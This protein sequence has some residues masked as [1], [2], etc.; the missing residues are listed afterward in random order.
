[1][2]IRAAGWATDGSY[3]EKCVQHADSH[4]LYRFDNMTAVP[5]VEEKLRWNSDAADAEA[6]WIMPLIIREFTLVPGY[7]RPV[8]DRNLSGCR[9]TSNPL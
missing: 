3:V 1:M 9:S 5:K 7:V 8:G 2:R 6:S 4:N